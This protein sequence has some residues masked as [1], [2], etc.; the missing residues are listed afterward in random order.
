MAPLAEDPVRLA[1]A[2]TGYR[3][4]LLQRVVMALPDRFRVTGVLSRH[5]DPAATVPEVADLDAL[6]A[7]D[8]AFVLVA[9]PT[10]A[11]PAL[12]ERLV[13]RDVKVLAETPAAGDEAGL[14]RLWQR[15]GA[16]GLVQVAEQYPRHP[17]TVA[18]IATARSGVIGEVGSAQLSLTQ[19]Y[20]AAAV[21][22]AVLGVGDA[23]AE[24]RATTHRAPLAA[25]WGRAGWTGDDAPRPTATTIATL[26]FGGALGLYDFT[27]GQTRNPLRRSR[28]VARGDLGEIV[29]ERVVRR[30]GP[31][32]VVESD[33]LRRDLG[34]HG[35][36]ED[37]DLVQISL[38]GEVL[39]RNA[40]P[41]ARLSDEELAIAD[42]LATTARWSAG[43]GPAPYPFA[44]AAQDQLLGLAIERAAATGE[45]VRTPAGAGRR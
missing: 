6:L 38:D 8:P 31:R 16:S 41:G 2:G 42:L 20:H 27:D 19:T 3:A 45:P 33:L 15:I 26:D 10:A 35:D 18:R 21:L 25:P 13:E 17:M 43:D 12:V 40:F 1:I 28:F 11:A 32:T 5:P 44:E 30:T 34:A 29:D 37:R 23:A 36:F 14:H 22:R 7:A 39:W 4:R 24:V 9:V